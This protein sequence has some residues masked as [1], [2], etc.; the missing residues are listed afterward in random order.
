M[1]ID[2]KSPASPQVQPS[3]AFLASERAACSK[4]LFARYP[5]LTARY[6]TQHNILHGSRAYIDLHMQ[7]R[8]R[9]GLIT[10]PIS[11]QPIVNTTL[12]R[13]FS[14]FAI[15]ASQRWQRLG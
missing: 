10:Y 12:S 2:G 13:H 3:P 14:A 7:G 15:I 8:S 11:R 5:C 6:G 4:P 1:S 9:G